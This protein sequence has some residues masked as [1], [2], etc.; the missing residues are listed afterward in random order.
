[1]YVKKNVQFMLCSDNIIT[2]LSYISENKIYM[3]DI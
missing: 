1:M 3:L 2:S